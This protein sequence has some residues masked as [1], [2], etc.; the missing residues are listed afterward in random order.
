MPHHTCE[1]FI[2]RW[3]TWCRYVQQLVPTTR[4]PD[5]FMRGLAHHESVRWLCAYVYWLFVEKGYAASTT[6]QHVSA[7]HHFF[8]ARIADQ[9][10]FKSP[11]LTAAR[12]GIHL[13]QRLRDTINDA[14]NHKR[15]PVSF[16]IVEH[17]MGPDPLHTLE[18]DSEHML[19]AATFVAF[20][21]MLRIGEYTKQLTGNDHALRARSITF[22]LRH[23]GTN[24]EVPANKLH[25]YVTHVQ[26][27]AQTIRDTKLT[28][29]TR[30]GDRDQKGDVMAFLTADLDQEPSRNLALILAH[31]ALTAAFSHKDDVFFSF[32]TPTRHPGGRVT[33]PPRTNLTPEAV[34]HRLRSAAHELGIPADIIKD[35]T[36]HSLR[37]GGAST[38][39]NSGVADSDIMSTGGWKSLPCAL[40]YQWTGAGYHRRMAG[41][42]N[43]SSFTAAYTMHDTVMH[44]ASRRNTPVALGRRS[45]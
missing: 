37:I 12:S 30:K 19:R 32:P 6:I 41:K 18:A 1:I 21:L 4:N 3:Q 31:W 16:D 25:L 22:Q 45:H 20:V 42:M 29:S 35:I 10:P 14:I 33:P 24:I 17:I 43:T 15:V 28:F 11:S 44:M 2:E 26:I 40:G 13:A 9:T 38:Y 27:S 7:V 39:K 34:S 36:P 5:P 8:R 23:N